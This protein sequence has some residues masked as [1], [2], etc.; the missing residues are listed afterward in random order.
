MFIG[1]NA[2]FNRLFNM[3]EAIP[4]KKVLAAC[5][6]PLAACRLPLAACRLPI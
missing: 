3:F 5:R 6:L 2:I 4:L 1:L